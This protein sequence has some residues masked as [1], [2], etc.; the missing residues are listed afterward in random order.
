LE[1]FKDHNKKQ[2]KRI[3]SS[4]SPKNNQIKNIVGKLLDDE[5]SEQNA[6]CVLSDEDDE[7]ENKQESIL[8]YFVNN[9]TLTLAA[10]GRQLLPGCLWIKIWNS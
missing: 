1:D 4:P 3:Q 7:S 8:L 2:Q 5:V 6:E 10:Y 9:K